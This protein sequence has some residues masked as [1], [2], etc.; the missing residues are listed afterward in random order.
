MKINNKS[1]IR[2]TVGLGTLNQNI[3]PK[4]V[5]LM[6][7]ILTACGALIYAYQIN[8]HSKTHAYIEQSFNNYCTKS[9][10]VL[11]KVVVKGI[12][13]QDKKKIMELFK[14][15]MNKSILNCDLKELRDRIEQLKWVESAQV[16]HHYPMQMCVN[17]IEKEPYALWQHK[18]TIHLINRKGSVIFA[19]KNPMSLDK[20]STLPLFVGIGAPQ[21]AHEILDLLNNYADLKSKTTAIIRINNRRWNLQFGK[22]LIIKFPE[23]NLNQAFQQLQSFLKVGANNLDHIDIID[24]RFHKKIILRLSKHSIHILKKSAKNI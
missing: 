18:K 3:N 13:N 2:N 16:Y 19:T 1:K 17:I 15:Y 14:P 10:I 4:I 24:L 22:N 20:F 5:V 9:G 6:M 21:H 8:L 7:A 12:V 11:Q 23:K